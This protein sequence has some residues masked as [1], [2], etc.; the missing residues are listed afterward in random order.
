MYRMRDAL[1]SVGRLGPRQGA[2][3]AARRPERGRD[4]HGAQTDGE[5][6]DEEPEV[7]AERVVEEAAQLW[8]QGHAECGHGADGP[9]HGAHD[10]GAEVLADEDRVEG[11]HAAV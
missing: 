6:A 2:G 4:R 1:S 7:A 9:E 11:H 8:A 3:E 5:R 10:P